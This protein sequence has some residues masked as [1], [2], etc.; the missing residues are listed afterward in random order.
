MQTTSKRCRRCKVAPLCIG[1]LK[2]ALSC[3]LYEIVN[4]DAYR[5]ERGVTTFMGDGRDSAMRGKMVRGEMEAA[6]GI[7][8]G[9]EHVDFMR[10]GSDH[11]RVVILAE[12]TRCADS[13]ECIAEAVFLLKR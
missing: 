12:H 5:D 9:I 8:M 7:S 3:L 1:N 10:H 13:Y 11:G 2:A 6:C 4:S